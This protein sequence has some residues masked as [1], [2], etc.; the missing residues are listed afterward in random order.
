MAKDKPLAA[1]VL[2]ELE[3]LAPKRK[4]WFDRLSDDAKEKMLEIKRLKAAGQCSYSARTIH[5]YAKT[6]GAIVGEP[7]IGEWLSAKD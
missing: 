4:T 3:A 7:T 5:A 2:A 1:S 6:L